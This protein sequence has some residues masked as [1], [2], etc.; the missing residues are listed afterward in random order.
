MRGIVPFRVWL[1]CVKI[2]DEK[3]A[4]LEREIGQQLEQLKVTRVP[5][6]TASKQVAA[7]S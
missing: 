3:W 5:V 6:N 4:G 7:S 1:M 2:L